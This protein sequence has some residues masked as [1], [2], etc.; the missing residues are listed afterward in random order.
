MPRSTPEWIGKTDDAKV[1]SRV[2]QRVF[3]RFDGTCHITGQ[4]IQPG[5]RWELEHRTALILGGE[6]R[7]SNL[8]PALSEAHKKKT[9]LE[10]ALKSKIAKVRAKHTG[11]TLPTGTLKSQGFPRSE[12]AA[13]RAERPPLPRRP[14]FKRIER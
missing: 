2:R 11:V 7:E 3:D 12:K 6:H 14:I 1:P 8:A 9:A 13:K 5:D 10:M 4:K